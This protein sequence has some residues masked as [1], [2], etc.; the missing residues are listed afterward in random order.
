MGTVPYKGSGMSKKDQVEE[1]FDD[2]SS[3]YDLLNH[4]FSFNIDKVWR[5]K[6]VR[7]LGRCEPL[8][9]L[10][11]ATG[12]ADFALAAVRLNPK[13][14]T[15]IDLSEGMLKEGRRK[16]ERM[17]LADLIELLKADSEALP[18]CDNSFDA[19]IVGFG[20]RNFE[21]SAKALG[22]IYRV[23]KPGGVFIVLEFS[24]PR[25]AAFKFFYSLY[26][27]KVLP[28]LG[29]VFSKN[30]RAYSYLPASVNVFPDGEYFM[31]ILENA[32]F[33]IRSW[34]PLTFGIASIYEVQKPKIKG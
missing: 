18:F 32:G 27:N 34:M 29:G 15:G 21:N 28:W 19:S 5:R 20:V 17:G 31:S 25:N 8:L 3:R 4:L 1:M 10:D 9:I 24:Q 11:V 33:E 2:I 26:F 14:I 30:R 6:A 12:T 23:L 16:I 13:K 22:E 7:L